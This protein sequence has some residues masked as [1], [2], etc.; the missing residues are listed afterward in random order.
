M[1]DIDNL[2]KEAIKNSDKQKL[3]TYRSLKAKIIEFKT[4]K[5]ARHYGE[6]EEISLIQKMIKERHESSEMY[7]SN[8][9]EDLSIIEDAQAKIL[10]DLLPDIPKV[11]DVEK[12]INDNYPNGIE[13]N[14]MG[15][16]IKDIKAKFI[17]IDGKQVSD[18]VKNILV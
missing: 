9:R 6:S 12:Y 13:K 3:T 11:E 7:K 4:A 10:N 17:G 15:I 2:I 1:I 16:V 8:N 18:L 14:K 5:N